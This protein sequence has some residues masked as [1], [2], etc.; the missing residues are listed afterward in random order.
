MNRY[1]LILNK[2]EQKIQ[3]EKSLSGGWVKYKDA[4]QE[5]ARLNFIIEQ[6]KKDQNGLDYLKGI[7]G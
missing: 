6:L 5:I 3:A 4:Q 7:F 1:K 2:K